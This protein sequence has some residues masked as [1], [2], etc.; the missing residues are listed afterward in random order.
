MPMSLDNGRLSGLV[1]RLFDPAAEAELG[2]SLALVAMHRGEVVAE[3]Y[4]RTPDTAFGPGEDVGPTTTLISW[5]VA[6]SIT[7]ALVGIAVADG[8]LDPAAP[9]PVPEWRNDARR[10]ITLQ[11]LLNMRSGLQ[12][13]ED[14]VDGEV[15]HVIDMLFGSGK[16][17][18]AAY[19]AALPLVAE[20]G[21]QWSYSS[22]TTNI[23]CRVLGE[24][25]GGG[26]D[27]MRAFMAERLFD[28]LGM[29]TAIPRFDAAGTFIGSSFVYASARDFAAFGELY[30]NGGF[31]DG[32]RILPSGWVEHA[33]TPIPVPD[34]ERFGYGAHWWLWRD[35][36]GSLGC[37]G[38]ET[39]RVLVFPERELVLVR[40]GKTP[41]ELGNNVDDLLGEM[42]K[43][44]ASTRRS[45]SKES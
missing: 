14:Y 1:D 41:A 18:V 3:R 4:G 12:F 28:P 20:P 8:L 42:A 37:H 39:Q 45:A 6:K 19:A 2:I 7:H 26:A 10:N 40:L 33:G 29:H 38:Y 27:G 43:C 15:S 21:S 30:R 25:I 11:H 16:D 22:G 32:K 44:A 17:D 13:V 36:P 24:A 34:T 5:S 9:A 31:V 23:I 35:E